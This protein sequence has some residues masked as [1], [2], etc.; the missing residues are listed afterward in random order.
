MRFLIVVVLALA[1]F[2]ASAERASTLDV[3]LLKSNIDIDFDLA[4]GDTD[5]DGFGLRYAR[6]FGAHGY[7]FA[8]Y[9][10]ASYDRLTDGFFFMDP[11]QTV[12]RGGVGAHSAGAG[13]RWYGALSYVKVD[14]AYGP[15]ADDEYSDSGFGLEAGVRAAL[16][17][18]LA[19]FVELGNTWAGDMSGFAYGFGLDFAF[20]EGFHGILEYGVANLD[21]EIESDST[22]DTQFTDTRLGLRWTF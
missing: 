16:V 11:E 22:I 1:P 18:R 5:G 6:D 3:Y 9:E 17:G 7:W 19:G 8:E 20:T 10:D 13:P 21:H 12:M 15:D 2:A 4:A 14:R